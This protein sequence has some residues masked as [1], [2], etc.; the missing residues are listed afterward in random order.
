MIVNKPKK[1]KK[2]SRYTILLIIM[3]IVFSIIT[4]KLVYIQIY[5]HDDYQDKANTTSTRF[6]SEKAPRGKIIDQNGNIL[7]TNTQTFALTYTSTNESKDAFYTTVDSIIDIL[8]SNGEKIQDDLKLKLN[9]NNEWYISY[10]NTDADLV[11]AEDIRFKR[12]RGLN[13]QVEKDLKLNT[14][15]RDLTEKEIEK[16]NDELYNISPEDVFYYLV[17]SYSLIDLVDP[18]PSDEQKK[19]YN[20]MTGKEITEILLDKGYSYSQ[21]RNY[22][23]IKD[24]IKMKSF[25]GY[26]SVTITSNL[27]WDTASIILQRQ[28]DLPGIDVSLEPTRSY[29]YGT[30]ASSV[31]GYLSSINTANE[32]KY[33]LKGYDVSSDLIGVSGIESAFE[34]QLKG[35]TG[36]TTVKVNSKGQVTEELFKLEAYPGNDVHLSI[37][38]NLQYVAE[39]AMQDTMNRIS[40]EEGGK[41]STANRGA[42]VA[43]EAKTGR[44][45][46]LVSLPNYDPNVFVLPGLL[47]DEEMK[48]YFSPDLEAFGE[49]YIREKG[50]TGIKTVDDLFP[51]DSNGI[52]QDMYDLY[53]RSFYNYA[54]QGLI[55]PGST[56]KPMT[57]IA[58]LESGVITP[59]ERVADLGKYD[60][61]PEVFGG[62]FAPECLAYTNY[63]GSHGSVNIESALAVSCN[64]YFYE[65]GYRLY[66]QGLA[67]GSKID[68]LNGIAKYAWRFGLGVDPNGKQ[69]PSTGIEITENFGQVYNFQSYRNIFIANAK[70]AIRDGVESG[71]F[72]GENF[73]PFDYSDREDD[74]EA[75]KEAK[76]SLK[77][78][79]TERLK[80]F[81]ENGASTNADEFAKILREDIEKI[82]NLSDKYKEN[83]ASYESN[84]GTFDIS[85]QA[86]YVS[87]AIAQY[88]I[89]DAGTQIISPGEEIF[90][91][92]GQGMNNFTPLQLA[93]YVSTIVNRGTRYKLH[94]V[95]K[96]TNP[97]G[98]VI[99]EY[100]PEILDQI[101]L[102]D[103]TVNAIIEGMSKVNEDETGT[104]AATFMNFPIKTGGKTGTA[105]FRE[106][107]TDYGR[108]PYA[109]Y[110]SFAPLEDPEIVF[111]GVVYDGGHGG[112]VAP[113]A[114]AIYEQYFKNRILE[115]NPNYQFS[116]ILSGIP[117]DNKQSK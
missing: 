51:K 89:H 31:V 46:A 102:K 61:H 108:A 105:D 55:P 13:E 99:K 90:A 33:E 69:N 85:K 16:V 71:S 9:E 21:L 5:K 96:V 48:A 18:D 57:G 63:G 32:E 109:T 38:K 41:Y 3:T 8:N 98:E 22:I 113:V 4:I 53:P 64:Y 77:S 12:D 92:I 110:V 111:V 73:I 72:R 94:L 81:G 84:G 91:S 28:N 115:S 27:K 7:A 101:Q 14:E 20:K 75:L 29:P 17:K 59:E 1:K 42:C 83:V 86:T 93:Q 52:R 117:S 49:K 114:K 23:L 26:K 106:D 87:I 45:L 2:I 103:S 24:K 39:T 68:G 40:S 37:D 79:I 78:K 58:G 11:R 65:I 82:M 47:S 30:L 54:T 116:E 100:G 44:I 97:D 67:N 35:V 76:T 60:V 66:M 56:F 34:E 15:E 88:V 10:E 112:S 25:Q 95:D 70:F 80:Q 104:A 74:S 6:V 50:L 62:D 107:Q 43:V 19:I 36:G